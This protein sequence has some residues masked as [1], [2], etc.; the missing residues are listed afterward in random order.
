V[1]ARRLRDYAMGLPV[2]APVDR[3]GIKRSVRRVV[4]RAF[5]NFV[6]RPRVTARWVAQE[7]QYLFGYAPECTVRE[8]WTVRCHPASLSTFAGVSVVAEYRAEFDGFVR[9]CSDGMRLL[10]VGSHFGMFTMAALRFGGTGVR[11]V[12][13]DPSA[14]ANRVLR[15]NLKLMSALE[16]VRVVEAAVAARIGKLPMLTTGAAGDHF[17]IASNSDRPDAKLVKMTTVSELVRATGYPFTHLKIDVE[18]H[19]EHVI[20]GGIDFIREY[21][22]LIFLELHGQILRE[23]GRDP[24]VVTDLLAESGYRKYEWRG[25]SIGAPEAAEMDIARIVCIPG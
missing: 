6:R 14:Y 7:C 9:R 19:E 2:N 20:A 24:R 13:V 17:L 23:S 3:S 21:K 25:R 18:G 10:D 4:P 11:V 5:R 8:S 12:A 22:P 1:K 16:R 15:A